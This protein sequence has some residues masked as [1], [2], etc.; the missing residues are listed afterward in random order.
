MVLFV[1]VH[2]HTD[3]CQASP[4][5][6]LAHHP[7]F[8]ADLDQFL[9]PETAWVVVQVVQAVVVVVQAVHKL[10]EIPE[11]YFK[12]VALEFNSTTGIV[13]ALLNFSSPVESK[14]L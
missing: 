14:S 13:F 9:S 5:H 8:L 3:V 7:P 10:V 12:N 4:V 11:Q 6:L 2:L 1:P